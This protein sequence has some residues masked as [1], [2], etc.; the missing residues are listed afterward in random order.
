M[1]AMLAWSKPS[2]QDPTAP[3]QLVSHK[4]PGAKQKCPRGE[5]RM[6]KPTVVADVETLLWMLS[7]NASWTPLMNISINLNSMKRNIQEQKDSI[8][9]KQQG[10]DEIK[11][12]NLKGFEWL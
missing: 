11:V 4:S 10:V 2:S 3:E 12:K 8:H 1:T 6:V 9:Y 5:I 7:G